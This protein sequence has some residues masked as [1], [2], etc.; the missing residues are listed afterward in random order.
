MFFWPRDSA[1]AS[2]A[3]SSV[4]SRGSSSSA[5]S[6]VRVSSSLWGQASGLEAEPEVQWARQRARQASP[7]RRHSSHTE[8]A[9]P[10]RKTSTERPENGPS[11]GD[12]L[13]LGR[14]AVNGTDWCSAAPSSLDLLTSLLLLL[15]LLL[16]LPALASTCGTTS[17]TPLMQK[18]PTLS[19]VRCSCGLLDERGGTCGLG[20]LRSSCKGLK[21]LRAPSQTDPLLLLALLCDRLCPRRD[22]GREEVEEEPR[23]RSSRLRGDRKVP[24]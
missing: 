21:K 3:C 17:P 9:P 13:L 15:L 14:Q 24:S 23:K 4:C 19:E 1:F 8:H 6:I 16:K 12:F 18:L 5:S 10:Q 7:C 22:V 2:C 20:L 11:A